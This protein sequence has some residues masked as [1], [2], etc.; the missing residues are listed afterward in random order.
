[1]L[2]AFLNL[3]Y[4]ENR[5]FLPYFQKIYISA[6]RHSR[7]IIQRVIMYDEIISRGGEKFM[8]EASLFWKC[9]RYNSL[10]KPWRKFSPFQCQKRKNKKIRYVLCLFIFLEGSVLLPQ[11]GK[12][13]IKEIVSFCS[14]KRDVQ[15]LTKDQTYEGKEGETREQGVSLDLK[16]GTV[17][18]W[19]RVERVVQAELD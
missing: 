7:L 17:K 18:L 11:H 5:Y 16:E 8:S 4:N 10:K 1:M 6:S 15:E 19:N 14:V 13:V 3:I 12:E 9:R 2:E